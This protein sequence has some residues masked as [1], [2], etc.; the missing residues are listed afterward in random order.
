MFYYN[1]LQNLTYYS[2]S[3]AIA[4]YYSSATSKKITDLSFASKY[5][6]RS[7]LYSKIFEITKE[8]SYNFNFVVST[9]AYKGHH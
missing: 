3:V 8:C 4:K 7:L 6:P 1:N 2:I 9:C 5:V